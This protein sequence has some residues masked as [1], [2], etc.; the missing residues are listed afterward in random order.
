MMGMPPVSAA[1]LRPWVSLAGI[2]VLSTACALVGRA[3][4]PW[5]KMFPDFI[6]YWTAGRITADGQSPYDVDLQVRI[7]QAQ[8][9][10]KATDGRGVLDFLPYYYPPWFAMACTLF[11]P[12]GY[13]AGKAAWFFL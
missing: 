11:L 13:Q 7:Q 3:I 12:M 1:N 5:E 4:M 2:T 6:T 8:G 9:W 10:D